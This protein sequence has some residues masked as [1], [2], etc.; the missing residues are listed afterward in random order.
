M[1]I[2]P[3][4][5]NTAVI[6][7]IPGYNRNIDAEGKFEKELLK[8]VTFI[9]LR[10]TSYKFGDALQTHSFFNLWDDIKAT[11]DAPG[12]FQEDTQ[13]AQVLF[14]KILVKMQ[15]DLGLPASFANNQM[16][17][18][19]AAN[20]ST[21]NEVLSNSFDED[22][23]LMAKVS[24]WS[25]N[26][27]NSFGGQLIKGA[28]G[29][30]H[31]G[32]I[33]ELGK[34]YESMNQAAGANSFVDLIAGSL[35]GMDMAVPSTWQRSSYT[36]TLSLMIKLVSPTGS[37][38]CIQKNILEPLLYLLAAASPITYGGIMYGFPM[39]WNVHAHGITNFRLGSIAAMTI[40]RGS[41]ETTFT[42]MLQPTVID[43]RLTLIPIMND[44]AVQVY[45]DG[46][47]S[48]YTEEN[49]KWLGVQHPGD[50]KR[51]LMNNPR[52]IN[53]DKTEIVSIKL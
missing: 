15:T 10:P 17:R 45:A 3:L 33:A 48:I 20:E 40:T 38:K 50:I 51:G 47:K 52:G 26:L 32:I 12:L 28:K 23:A 2:T 53:A 21:F 46:Q 11:L 35:W 6:G 30:S 49:Q 42:K 44:F 14:S 22:N 16:I 36:S 7:R 1:G 18:I 29:F 9:D 34:A 41:F 19:I 4:P 24:D 5:A 27:S 25:K 43:V 39:L 37:E 31:S 13:L 8:G